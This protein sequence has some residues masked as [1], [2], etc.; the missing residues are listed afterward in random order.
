MASA[1]LEPVTS[2][3]VGDHCCVPY[4]SAE[5]QHDIMAAYVRAGMAH[6]D[7]VAY[8]CAD[9]PATVVDTLAGRGICV[10]PLQERGQLQVIPPA[11]GYL[12]SSPFD[13][14][15][16]VA[17]LRGMVAA[18]RAAG[19]R[20]L[21]VTGE[22]HALR[23]HPGGERLLE[24]ERKVTDVFRN[25]PAVGL[26]QYDERAFPGE[27][28]AA[29]A[30]VHPKQVGP[31][32]LYDDGSLTILRTYAPPGVRLVGEIASSQD[33][34]AVARAVGTLPRLTHDLHVD[35]S[36]LRFL[37]V[38]GAWW[39]AQLAQQLDRHG[40]LLILRGHARGVLSVLRLAG[41]DRWSNVVIDGLA[42]C[43]DPMV[44]N[45]DTHSTTP[46]PRARHDPP[47]TGSCLIANP[48]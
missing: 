37:N 29:A 30:A 9:N 4:G 19:F 14:E 47:I 2:M 16:M 17:R 12:A 11:D 33:L 44:C 3:G 46:R 45:G 32:P 26:C 27:Q 8:F 48:E 28:I 21:R 18:A 36:G 24:Y 43:P 34:P 35:L 20:A 38:A 39:L 10:G 31:D 22:V 40:A 5:E 15:V 1:L 41:W 42:F 25:G 23:A 6:H 13:P 7:R